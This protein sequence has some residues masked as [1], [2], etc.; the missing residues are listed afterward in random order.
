MAVAIGVVS[1]GVGLASFALQL[2]ESAVKLRSFYKTAKNAPE[3]LEDTASYIETFSQV[4]LQIERDRVEHDDDRDRELLLRCI[5]ECRK[6]TGKIVAVAEKLEQMI[7][8]AKMAGRIYYALQEG[9]IAALC[10]DL[11]RAKS[12]LLQA[13][14]LYMQ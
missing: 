12:S 6:S 13:H 9:S 4:L 11:E 5:K 8:K 10:A 2:A 7:K 1:G 3:S 14:M